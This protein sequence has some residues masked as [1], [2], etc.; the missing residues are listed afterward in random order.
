MLP[1]ANQGLPLID[2]VAVPIVN[3]MQNTRTLALPQ[4]WVENRHRASAAT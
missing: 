1:T 4:A 2:G 3:N